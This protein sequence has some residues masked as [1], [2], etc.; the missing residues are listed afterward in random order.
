[1]DTSIN[2]LEVRL[3]RL[4]T[5]SIGNLERD[6]GQLSRVVAEGCP[7]HTTH[8][9]RQS[10]A[11]DLLPEIEELADHLEKTPGRVQ[12]RGVKWI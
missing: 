10:A 9:A 4:R 2:S 3:K 12:P 11:L 7:H 1:V 8:R 5:E 6:K